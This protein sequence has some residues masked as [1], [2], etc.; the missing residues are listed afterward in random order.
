MSAFDN[1]RGVEAEGNMILLPYLREK[2][3]GGLVL[4][5]KGTL[6]R[7]LQESVGDVLL[8]RREQL[9]AVELKCERKYTG[10]LFLETWSNRNLEDGRSHAER[11]QNTGWMYKLRADLLLYYFIDTDQLFSIKVLAL[12]RWFFGRGG[13]LGAYRRP[14][15]DGQ[16]PMFR[17]VKQEARDQANDTRG[18]LVPI[19]VLRS[20]I[21]NAI[22]ETRVRQRAFVEEAEIV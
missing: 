21:P 18:V 17:E 2:S 16:T 6:A 22:R 10:N 19:A 20:E 13:E 5:S 7:W 14:S 1:A 8:N 15:A 12:K 4:T 9:F 11:G 3:D